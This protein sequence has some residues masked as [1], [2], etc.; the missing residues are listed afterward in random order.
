MQCGLIVILVMHSWI[1][2]ADFAQHGEF[3]VVL[4][5][6]IERALLLGEEILE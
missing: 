2:S 1:R 4:E 6:L 5:S 3:V